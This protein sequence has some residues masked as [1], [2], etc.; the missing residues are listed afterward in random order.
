MSKKWA[1]FIWQSIRHNWRDLHLITLDVHF[2]FSEC[3]FVK[4]IINIQYLKR[5]TVPSRLWERV[6]KKWNFNFKPQKLKLSHMIKTNTHWWDTFHTRS[7]HC[8]TLV[9]SMRKIYFPYKNLNIPILEF[10]ICDLTLIIFGTEYYW[11]TPSLPC[12]NANFI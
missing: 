2:T 7:L 4:S 6:F 9:R 10:Q 1:F 12:V 3:L 5:I 8:I 11:V